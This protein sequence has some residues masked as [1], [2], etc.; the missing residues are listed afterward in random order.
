M[1]VTYMNMCA[2]MYMLMFHI[3]GKFGRAKL[4]NFGDWQILI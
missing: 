4:L 2:C 3:V 1:K